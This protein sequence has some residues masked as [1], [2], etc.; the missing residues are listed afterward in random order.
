MV[1][2]HDPPDYRGESYRTLPTGAGHRTLPTG[3]GAGRL[4]SAEDLA[5]S[6]DPGDWDIIVAGT[7]GRSAILDGQPATFA[8]TVLRAARRR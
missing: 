7:F 5:A 1:G 3:A 6:L 2:R 4:R 8:D